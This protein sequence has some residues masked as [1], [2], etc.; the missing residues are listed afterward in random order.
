LSSSCF[1]VVGLAGLLF[2]LQLS[3]LDLDCDDDDDDDDDENGLCFESI[4]GCPL[5][6]G[7]SC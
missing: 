1:L 4:V 7:G 3:L 6:T 5:I 2:L